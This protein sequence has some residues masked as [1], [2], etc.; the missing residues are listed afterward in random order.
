RIFLI[1]QNIKGL[2]YTL[3]QAVVTHS[4]KIVKE[5]DS[6]SKDITELLAI[7][8]EPPIELSNKVAK[9]GTIVAELS[10]KPSIEIGNVAKNMSSALDGIL[11]SALELYSRME[12]PIRRMAAASAILSTFIHSLLILGAYFLWI[13]YNT[14]IGWIMVL[15]FLMLYVRATYYALSPILKVKIFYLDLCDRLE[16]S[17]KSLFAIGYLTVL[18]GMVLPFVWP[19]AIPDINTHIYLFICA[20]IFLADLMAI[21]NYLVN[22]TIQRVKSIMPVFVTPQLSAKEGALPPP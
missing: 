16:D 2:L 5:V 22:K 3:E 6:L 1:V 8:P 13:S 4:E 14:Y 7:S 20:G 11:L 12:R 9:V 18:F 17:L 15:G 10:L 19:T 21:R